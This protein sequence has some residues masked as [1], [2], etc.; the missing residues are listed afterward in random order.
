MEQVPQSAAK[1]EQGHK[2]V[3][4]IKNRTR[5]SLL[6]SPFDFALSYPTVGFSHVS[7]C[8]KGT[9]FLFSPAKRFFF[10]FFFLRL[11]V[12]QS[13]HTAL[14][15]LDPRL[16]MQLRAHRRSS[17]SAIMGNDDTTDLRIFF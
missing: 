2:R 6:S 11:H 1:F 5:P 10:C 8:H 9:P 7:F 12:I 15:T 14:I 4:S 3:A 17:I 13:V 16:I